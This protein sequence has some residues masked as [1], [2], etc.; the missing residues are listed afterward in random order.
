MCICFGRRTLYCW[1]VARCGFNYSVEAVLGAILVMVVGHQKNSSPS[2]QF[3]L[4]FFVA[5]A[6]RHRLT[7]EPR[8]LGLMTSRRYGSLASSRVAEVGSTAASHERETLWRE[9]FSDP[10]Q[11]WDCR[12]E[13]MNPR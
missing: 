5:M 10:S 12:P 6:V 13:K 1:T 2:I 7:L 4:C 8:C 3:F 11:W 9:F